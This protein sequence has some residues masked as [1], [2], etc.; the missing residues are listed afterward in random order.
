MTSVSYAV[1]ESALVSRGRRFLALSNENERLSYLFDLDILQRIDQHACAGLHALPRRGLENA[2]VLYGY[3]E[4]GRKGERVVVVEDISPLESEHLFGPDFRLSDADR[5][6]LPKVANKTAVGIYRTHTRPD[7]APTID[8]EELW[9]AT[10]VSVPEGFLLIVAPSIRSSS[11][12]VLYPRAGTGFSPVHEFPLRSSALER[13]GAVIVAEPGAR[14]ATEPVNASGDA[15]KTARRPFRAPLVLAAALACC[16]V[17]GSFLMNPSSTPIPAEQTRERIQPVPVA[18]LPQQE[19]PAP[20]PDLPATAPAPPVKKKATATPA[21]TAPEK[22]RIIVPSRV[23]LEPAP[24][25][26]F[27]RFWSRF[28]GA[29]G[30]QRDFRGSEGYTP[31]RAGRQFSPNYP[32][33]LASELRRVSPIVVRLNL[34]DRGNVEKAKVLSRG[35]RSEVRNISTDTLRKWRFRPARVNG[36]SVPSRVNVVLHF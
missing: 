23:S 18:V 13:D 29:R 17:I 1:P 10:Q 14:P 27:R 5:G 22:P 11:T 30:F 21:S 35:V 34:D 24:D 2:G 26:A 19:Q 31:A 25:S 6:A 9:V 3:V 7:P 4:R 32:L 33:S 36:R 16:V 20:A 28:P 8:D 15:A 12:A